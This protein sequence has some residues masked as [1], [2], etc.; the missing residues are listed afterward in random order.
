MLN[1]VVNMLVIVM[2][3]MNLLI[4]VDC[5]CWFFLIIRIISIFLRIEIIKIMRYVVVLVV[6]RLVIG[7]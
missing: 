5:K 6:V 2:D 7:M 4:G 1:N 3:I